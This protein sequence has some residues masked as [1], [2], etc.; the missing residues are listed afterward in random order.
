MYVEIIK[1]NSIFFFSNQWF[2]W[3]FNFHLLEFVKIILKF[4]CRSKLSYWKYNNWNQ[5][6]KKS[7]GKFYYNNNNNNKTVEEED[8]SFDSFWT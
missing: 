8:L 7:Y 4:C 5:K 6:K 2:S 3:F 1:I